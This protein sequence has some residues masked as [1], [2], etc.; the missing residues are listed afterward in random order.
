MFVLTDG[1]NYVMENPMKSGDYI[2]T[3]SP[4]HAKK[5][6]YKQ[7]R[8]LV[9]KSRKKYSWIKNFQ[10][11]D[12]NTGKESEF[13]LNYKGNAGV[14]IESD[15]S[16]DDS[17]LDKI[18]EESNSIIG[19]AG[20]NAEQLS[21]YENLLNTQL[22]ICDSAESDIKHALEKYKEDNKGKKPQAHKAA[23]IGYLL[24]E[25]RDRHKKI[26]QCIRCVKIMQDAITYKYTIGKIKFELSKASSGEYKG[27]TEYWKM[28]LNIL[29]D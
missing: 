24:D 2:Q 17:I 8:S 10:L 11:V 14:Y 29:E 25:I 28:A 22:S 1:K 15:T 13:S 12:M 21:T 19:L 16:F 7:A 5:F 23:K 27:R 18:I 26:K 3:T 4:I 9:Q 20:W 6:T